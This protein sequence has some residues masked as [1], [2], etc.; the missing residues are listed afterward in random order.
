MIFQQPFLLK[1]IEGKYRLANKV[2]RPGAK[3]R[4]IILSYAVSSRGFG[5]HN[6]SLFPF[7]FFSS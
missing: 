2:K 7:Y 5:K 1:G 3:R 6:L 4:L